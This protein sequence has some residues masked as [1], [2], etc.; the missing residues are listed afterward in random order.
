MLAD[1]SAAEYRLRD[2]DVL[3]WDYRSWA[4]SEEAT[5]VVG[6]FPEPF[7]DGYAGRRRPVHVRYAS[8]QDGAARALGRLVRA[9]SVRSLAIRV[10]AGASSVVVTGGA[11]S[12][13][14]QAAA[15]DGP[16]RLV[17]RGV[18]R[19]LAARPELVRRHYAWPR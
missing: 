12:V 19:R 2:G 3:W 8:G 13:R 17:V 11:P 5:A 18:A 16:Y 9:A 10:P 6:A 7:L 1:R 14:M 15:P 4:R